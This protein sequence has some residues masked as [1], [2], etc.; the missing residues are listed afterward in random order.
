VTELHL[1]RAMCL[2]PHAFDIVRKAWRR[3]MRTAAIKRDALGRFAR[4]H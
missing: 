4:A 3:D 2:T 1:R